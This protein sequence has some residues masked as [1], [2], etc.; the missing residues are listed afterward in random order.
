[1]NCLRSVGGRDRRIESHVLHE[2]LV[3]ICVY[4]CLSCPVFKQRPCDRP[5]TRP[6]S[7]DVTFK[8]LRYHNCTVQEEKSKRE[9]YLLTLS[10]ITNDI[11]KNYVFNKT[12]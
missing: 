4:L 1:M 9:I 2:C 5:I 11:P 8:E 12:V 6:R 7:P 3:C 10:L